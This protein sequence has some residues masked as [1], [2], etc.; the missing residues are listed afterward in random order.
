MLARRLEIHLVRM[1]WEYT[2]PD[3]L[4]DFEKEQALETF[5]EPDPLPYQKN[6]IHTDMEDTLLHSIIKP[7]GVLSNDTVELGKLVN[8]CAQNVIE[9][10]EITEF[11]KAMA[12]LDME[13]TYSEELQSSAF[14]NSYAFQKRIQERIEFLKNRM[15]QAI[16][17]LSK[18]NL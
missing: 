11:A 3:D 15:T 14:R 7:T 4:T 16:E 17:I 9:R 6:L 18:T 5:H 10:F 2:I 8:F 13:D 12:A 1:I